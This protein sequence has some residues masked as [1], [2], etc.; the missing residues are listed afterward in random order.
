MKVGPEL[1]EKIVKLNP[2][3]EIVKEYGVKL[4]FD[5]KACCPF[6]E[7][8]TPSFQVYEETNSFHCYG[9]GAGTK[10]KELK[11]KDDTI[12]TDA[13]SDVIAFVANME[14][15]PFQEAC[16]MLMRRANIPIPDEKIDRELE[17]IKDAVMYRNR[18]Y[19]NQLMKEP[20]MI[21]YL[22]SRG[23]DKEDAK[24]WRLGYTTSN[25]PTTKYK[26]RLVFAIMEEHYRP[27]DAKTIALAYRKLNDQEKGP[28][29]IN[30]PNSKVY[31]KSHVLYGMNYAAPNIREKRYAIVMEGYV[32]VIISHKAG[33]NNSVAICGT[34]FTKE[35]IKSLRNK[36]DKLYLWLDG[37][38]AGMNGMMRCLPDLLAEGFTVMIV[39]SQGE[40]PAEVIQ[41]V[42]KDEVVNYIMK[43]ARPA[44]QL[45][46]DK[47]VSQY[48]AIA[49][50]ERIVALNKILPV[51][52]SI[53]KPAEKMN[54][55][56]VLKQK[57]G[58]L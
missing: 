14:G 21:K 26:D 12:V 30:D 33:L 11:R 9:C 57:L 27:D 19:Y 43:N 18:K 56:G 1:R 3:N 25:D 48:E 32:D 44:V 53:V 17:K 52:D 38:Q 28:K 6:H 40:D 23:M 29:Y 49:N 58:L 24:K 2:I 34:S 31:N 10:N 13:G 39:D 42:G 47:A 51:I 41:R 35:Q 46:I 36:T 8:D 22:E 5:G 15:I 55:Q 4:R 45:V 54:F 7:E 20:D 37:D 50:K 16:K